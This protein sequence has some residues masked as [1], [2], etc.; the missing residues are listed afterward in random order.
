MKKLF[1]AA[2]LLIGMIAGA[3]VLSSFSE[4]QREIRKEKE[5]ITMNEGWTKIGVYKGEGPRRNETFVIWQKEGMCNSYY[6]VNV[7]YSSNYRDCYYTNPDEACST[8]GVLMKDRDDNWYAALYGD[9]YII[10]F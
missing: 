9:K 1:I 2:S 6:W 8:T 7:P 4:P 10:D 3:T 5:Q